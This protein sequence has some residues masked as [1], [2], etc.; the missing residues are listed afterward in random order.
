M[1]CQDQGGVVDLEDPF[2][3]S[4]V[5]ALRSPEPGSDL[6]DLLVATGLGMLILIP[7]LT[8]LF[9]LALSGRLVYEDKPRP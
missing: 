8:W 7:A 4:E 1:F 3:I 9:R 5:Q 6:G 2:G